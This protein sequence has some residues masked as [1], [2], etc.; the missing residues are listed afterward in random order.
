MFHA[1]LIKEI[2]SFFSKRYCQMFMINVEERCQRQNKLRQKHG[3]VFGPP[4]MKNPTS[5][6]ATNCQ[7]DKKTCTYIIMYYY[8]LKVV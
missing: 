4:F 6:H 5:A 3:K 1:G 2:S 8:L 7:A